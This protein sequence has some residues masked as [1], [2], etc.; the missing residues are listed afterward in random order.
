MSSVTPNTE[1]NIFLIFL[2]FT[3]ISFYLSDYK[4]KMKGDENLSTS[5]L[6]LET[7]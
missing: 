4:L 1:G 6:S 5:H 3:G 7:A 2:H